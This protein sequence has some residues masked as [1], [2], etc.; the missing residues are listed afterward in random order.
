MPFEEKFNVITAFDVLEHL[1]DPLPAMSI[2]CKGL[3]PAGYLYL[4]LPTHKTL[5]DGEKSHYYKPLE[6]WLKILNQSGFKIVSVHTYYTIGLRAVM[7][8]SV[9]RINYASI[10]AQRID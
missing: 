8:P 3:K 1:Y 10:V 9:K 2:L 4:E 5:I 7:I 6:E